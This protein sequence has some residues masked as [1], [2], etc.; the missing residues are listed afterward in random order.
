MISDEEN[1]SRFKVRIDVS[2]LGI[3]EVRDFE[4]WLSMFFALTLSFELRK[5]WYEEVFSSIF[6]SSSFHSSGTV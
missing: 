2:F 5:I 6:F 4:T 3:C 1:I